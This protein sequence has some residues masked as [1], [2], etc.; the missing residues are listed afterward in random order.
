MKR[1][2][3]LSFDNFE[4]YSE[5]AFP[6]LMTFSLEMARW[7]WWGGWNFISFRT[8]FLQLLVPGIYTIIITT[9]ATTT[10]TTTVIIIITITIIII[11]F[12]IPTVRR[13]AFHL[14]LLKQDKGSL[15]P[16]VSDVPSPQ[17][18]SPVF[19]L[20]AAMLRLCGSVLPRSHPSLAT[21]SQVWPCPVMG[22]R[23]SRYL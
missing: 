19:S 11:G 16:S 14:E 1:T 10:T 5:N 7:R 3:L 20:P 8:S 4:Y 13:M 17:L 2:H 6:L 18:S 9:T 22:C 21:D 12:P 15:H 23:L